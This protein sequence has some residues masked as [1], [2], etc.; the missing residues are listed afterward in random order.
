MLFVDDD[1]ELLR[2]LREFAEGWG[3]ETLSELDSRRALATAI[4]FR[5]DLIVLDAVMPFM[6]GYQVF[7]ALRGEA[8]TAD[9]P[10]LFLSGTG[11]DVKSRLK[12]L[13]KGAWDYL[14]KPIDLDE[15]RARLA[16]HVS[17]R[18]RTL[19]SED[20]ATEVVKRTAVFLN[21]S[22]NN[23][24]CTIQLAAELTG[25]NGTPQEKRRAGLVAKN[26]QGIHDVIS[27]LR[28]IKRVVLTGYIGDERMLDIEKSIEEEAPLLPGAPGA[29]EPD[30]EAVADEKGSDDKSRER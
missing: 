27:K 4:Q 24:L 21:H 8:K 16:H 13:E 26:V 5:P 20:K 30:D 29:D 10:I 9:I 17:Q 12:G 15:L 3:Y 28:K 19:L 11:R 1:S 14:T 22:I 18:Q 2:L 23:L 7:D 25:A 6:D